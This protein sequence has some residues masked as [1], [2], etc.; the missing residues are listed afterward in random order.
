MRRNYALIGSTRPTPSMWYP[1]PESAACAIYM[2]ARPVF[3]PP[4]S[5]YSSHLPLPRCAA[6][7]TT[8]ARRRDPAAPPHLPVGLSN[9]TSRESCG[10]HILPPRCEMALGDAQIA[11]AMEQFRVDGIAECDCE[12][13]DRRQR[14]WVQMKV[15]AAQRNGLT[16]ATA[17]Y[18]THAD[19]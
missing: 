10:Q 9:P 6:P 13:L 8:A 16:S 12:E 3:L 14:C 1:L 2:H 18:A 5:P 11:K 15:I 7:P 4:A 19:R 17:T